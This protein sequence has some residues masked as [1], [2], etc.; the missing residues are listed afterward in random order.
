MRELSP[1]TEAV[2]AGRPVRVPDAP[3]NQPPVLA[4]VY[5]AGGAIEYGRHGSPTWEAFETA[6]GALEGGLGLAFPSG[7]AA[8]GA[9]L[10]LIPADGVVVVPRHA[11]LGTL[12]QLA[13]TGLTLRQVD[14]ADT[15]EVV[16]ACDGADL[17]LLESP[18]NPALEVADLPTTCAAGRAA[19][20]LVAVDNT[21]ATPFGQ[22]PIALGADLVVHSA[23]KFIA[24]HSDAVLGALVATDTDTLDRLKEHRRLS[25]T[26]P[27]VMETW[28]ALRGLRTLHLR[29]ERAAANAAVLA[30]RLAAHP[31]CLRVRYPG[32][33]TDPG[34][35]RATA[36]MRTFGAI[37]SV[38]FADG[39]TAEAFCGATRL[40]VNATSLG[41]VESTLERRRR[42]AGESPTIPEGLVRFSAGIEDPEDLWA[43]LEQALGSL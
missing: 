25:G 29:L 24:G 36:Q 12:G 20:A 5:N 43:D 37:L 28:L 9:V 34:H 14:V 27:G 41:A 18:T 2:H 33:P 13:R 8:V 42:W 38:E 26:A 35:A 19:G 32:L 40:W 23:T 30:P 11:Y 16:A 4:S 17:V 10:S 7:L 15:D 6:I 21:F 39:P 3:L 1:E 31:A 22:N